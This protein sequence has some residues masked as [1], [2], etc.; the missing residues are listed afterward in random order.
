MKRR[1]PESTRKKR[2]SRSYWWEEKKPTRPADPGI[3]LAELAKC[4][5]GYTAGGELV[6]RL[7]PGHGA[8]VPTC[9]G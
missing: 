9:E 3:T 7:H 4:M 8:D 2:L 1:G 5:H 6:R